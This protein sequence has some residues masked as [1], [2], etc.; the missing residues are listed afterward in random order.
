MFFYRS[1][2]ITIVIVIIARAKKENSILDHTDHTDHT[3]R[4]LTEERAQFPP[5]FS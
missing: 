2:S 4:D 1:I 5:G 3:L